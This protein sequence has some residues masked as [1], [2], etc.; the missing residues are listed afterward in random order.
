[1][2]S[3]PFL[4]N[5]T[6]IGII[7]GAMALVALIEALIPLHA[8]GRWNKDHLVPNLLLTFITFAISAA[9]NVA[10]VMA[11][12][13]FEARG[14]GLLHLAGLPAL[15][16]IGIVVV[17]LDFAFYLCHVSMHAIPG[18]WRW[19]SVHHSDP[20]VDVTTTV[21]QHPGETVIRP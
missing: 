17:A 3:T 7:L 15:L 5:S 1:M 13:W 9:F 18:F 21:R 2:N 6:M 19:H 16:H 4:T 10:L 12:A 14:G 11:L 20:A 8:R